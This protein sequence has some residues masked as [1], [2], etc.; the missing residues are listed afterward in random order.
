VPSS[1]STFVSLTF[2]Q[3]INQSILSLSIRIFNPHEHKLKM[4]FLT[5]TPLLRTTRTFAQANRAFSTSLVA[6]KVVP[7]AV[8]EPVKKI[9]RAVSDKLVDGIELGRMCPFLS[10]F[11]YLLA[12]VLFSSIATHHPPILPNPSDWIGSRLPS[13]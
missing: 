11:H 5:R 10:L 7:D 4:S 3:S 6:R 2:N 1:F 9:D 8:K 13:D 12:C